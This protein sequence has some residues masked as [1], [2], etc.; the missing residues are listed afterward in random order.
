MTFR[1]TS[2]VREARD[3]SQPL[4][5]M[6]AVGGTAKNGIDYNPKLARS[7]ETPANQSSVT[8]DV[9]PLLD[10]LAEGEETV[11]VALMAD[12]RGNHAL[13]S[14]SSATVTVFDGE[15]PSIPG[16]L[17]NDGTVNALDFNIL[18]ENYGSTDCGNIADING[19]CVVDIFDYNILQEN[20]G[21]LRA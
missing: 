8:L 3:V 9:L 13:G 1:L 12:R 10:S 21:Q 19:D 4:K 7:V 17:N 20:Y 11:T 14:S 5:I 2:G 15:V 18:S 16:D 6:V